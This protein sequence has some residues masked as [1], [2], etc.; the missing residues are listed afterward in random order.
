MISCCVQC[1]MSLLL[2]K[3]FP[4]EDFPDGGSVRPHRALPVR[5]DPRSRAAG[6]APV[7]ALGGAPVPRCLAGVPARERHVP[8]P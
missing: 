3:F 6:A 2:L 1:R 4:G 5:R 7:P 8:R